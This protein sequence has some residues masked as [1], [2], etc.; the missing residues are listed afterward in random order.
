VK[1]WVFG[2]ISDAVVFWCFWV[3]FGCVYFLNFGSFGVW[4]VAL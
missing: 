4:V 3:V 2:V 1:F